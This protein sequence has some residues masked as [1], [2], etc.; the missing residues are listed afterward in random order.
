MT[1]VFTRES[2]RVIFPT[3]HYCLQCLNSIELRVIKSTPGN[4][5][6]NRSP[7]GKLNFT[8]YE[9]NEGGVCD[10]EELDI[11]VTGDAAVGVAGEE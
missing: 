11:L 3:V 5:T 8:G 9:S 2:L 6:V 4:K 1:P 7:V 10:L